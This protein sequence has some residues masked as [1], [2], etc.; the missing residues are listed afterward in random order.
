[1]V[2]A[3]QIE[4]TYTKEEIL[5]FYLNRIFFGESSFGIRTAAQTYFGKE[6]KDLNP[7]EVALLADFPRLPAL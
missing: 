5:T 2:L 3:I 7:A 4:R 1:L 6:L